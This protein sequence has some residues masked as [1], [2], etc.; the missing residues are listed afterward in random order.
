MAAAGR[1]ALAG[2]AG[3]AMVVARA[4]AT[5]LARASVDV[6][7]A[8]QAFHWFDRARARSEFL[9]ILRPGGRVVLV[10]NVRREEASALMGGYEDLL[11][12][13]GTDYHAVNHQG[14][15][16][17]EVSEFFGR[18]GAERIALHHHQVLDRE[19][20]RGRLLSASYVPGADD[21]RSAPMLEA[22]DALFE[23]HASDGV[24]RFE[25]EVRL[26]FGRLG[27]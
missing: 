10:W 25:Y 2:R 14:I 24:V 21:P 12:A 16:A 18:G 5:A 6:V 19:G 27:V 8:G 11:R 23:A 7:A 4:E 15:T 17:G 13:H 20:L 9:R 26:Y 1:R 22:L 3:F